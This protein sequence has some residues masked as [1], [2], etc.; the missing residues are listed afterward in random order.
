MN[1][2]G[3]GG[4]FIPLRKFLKGK[5]RGAGLKGSELQ[6]PAPMPVAQRPLKSQS[7]ADDDDDD[8]K[9]KTNPSHTMRVSG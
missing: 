6:V 5:K 3:E 9:A 8:D 1:Y 7:G 4:A 2:W